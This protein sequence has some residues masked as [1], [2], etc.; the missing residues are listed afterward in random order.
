MSNIARYLLQNAQSNQDAIAIVD[1][2]LVRYKSTRSVHMSDFGFDNEQITYKQ[3]CDRFSKLATGIKSLTG[4][5]GGDRVVI[6]MENRPEFI[7]LIFAC[8]CAGVCVVPVN[9]KLHA[10]EILHIV[11]D[12]GAKI[13]MLSDKIAQSVTELL[14]TN[15]AALR[16]FVVGSD[17]FASLYKP[18]QLNCVDV[19]PNDVAWIF[20]TSGTTGR[21][22]GAMLTHHNLLMMSLTY[23]T[24]VE[25]VS[26]GDVK[27]HA[28]PLSHGSGL[29][30]LPHLLGGGTQVIFDGFEPEDIIQSLQVFNNVTFFAAPTMVMRMIGSIKP[31]NQFEGLRTLIY[32]GGPMYVSDLLKA[33][34]VFGPKLYQ[35]YGQG[36]SPMTISGLS[37]LHHMGDR[38]AVHLERLSTCGPARTGV[39]IKIVDQEGAELPPGEIGEI[40]TRN[41]MVMSGYWNNPTA[42]SQALRGGW[43]WTGD[44]GCLDLNGFLSLRDRSKDLIISGGTNIYPREIEEVLLRH[45]SVVECSVVGRPHADWGEEAVAFVV[46]N[47][48]NI[49]HEELDKLC[50]DN[51]ARFKRPKAYIFVDSLPKNNYGKVLKTDLRQL[52][53]KENDHA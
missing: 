13:A 14:Q 18:Q 35:L 44:I 24:D 36:E 38:G 3:F 41:Q 31:G 20:Y 40:I 21:P 16:I 37:K 12:S 23:C 1:K 30:S 52:L 28:A 22:K 7:D 32:G 2:T 8:W 39:E 26:P 42:T 10:K 27:F 51:I 25:K 34:D 29:Y 33:L 15:A 11:S 50:F 5:E 46:S 9:A 47:G 17:E 4:L 53:I 43:L 19:Q 45:P 49:D 6:C 48:K